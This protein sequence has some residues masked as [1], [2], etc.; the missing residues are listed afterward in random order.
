M[1]SVTLKSPVRHNDTEYVA[2]DVIT[3]LT[4]KEVD[5][6][7][8]L[9][10]AV[11]GEVVTIKDDD[12]PAPTT[13]SGITPEQA[14]EIKK[15]TKAKLLAALSAAGIEADD[16]EKAPVLKEKLTA[17]WAA[18]S[19]GNDEDGELSAGELAQIAGMER[20]ELIESLEVAGI[21]FSENEYDD[22]LRAKLKTAWADGAAG[23]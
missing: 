11:P 4:Q 23:D 14:A 5:R 2:G 13:E 20:A 3:G 19:A 1:A 8:R 16:S 17:A 21:E 9:G 15:M 7:V 12:P 18:A 10:V 6:L 22:E